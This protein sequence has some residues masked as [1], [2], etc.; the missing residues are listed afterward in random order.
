M[1]SKNKFEHSETMSNLV[2]DAFQKGIF[3]EASH[4]TKVMKS[5]AEAKPEVNL[6]PSDNVQENL[7]KLCAGLR[8]K[9]FAAYA[10]KVEDRIVQLKQAEVHLYNVHDETGEDLLEFAHPE[11]SPEVAESQGGHGVVEDLIA[12]HKKSVEVATKSAAIKNDVINQVKLALIGSGT[13]FLVSEAAPSAEAG[14]A[15][16][17]I[18]DS[19]KDR[20][21]Q[22]I[23]VFSKKGIAEEAGVQSLTRQITDT[24]MPS[25]DI[26]KRE[27]LQSKT[28]TIPKFLNALRKFQEYFK[29]SKQSGTFDSQVFKDDDTSLVAIGMLQ[30]IYKDL[31]SIS[32]SIEKG[33]NWIPP[34]DDKDK[35]SF[36]NPGKWQENQKIVDP[37][38]EEKP[39][40]GNT[41]LDGT[42]QEF[43]NVVA[44][45]MNKFKTLLD[46]EDKI[47][48][49]IPDND[50]AKINI[51]DMA[52]DRA[53]SAFKGFSE[54]Y[55][56]LESIKEVSISKDQLSE[57]C[58]N[59][60]I[61]RGKSSFNSTTELITYADAVYNSVL[62]ALGKSQ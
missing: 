3:K 17:S 16:A 51:F 12:E 27:A 10:E 55:K 1:T 41:V 59:L 62:K 49:P 38:K 13:S 31:E 18:I 39:V 28:E 29:T 56:S 35:V 34:V 61:F 20:F 6:E 25:L 32:W 60:N 54:L 48:E 42:V 9:G 37:K 45:S 52:F 21:S 22:L 4:I 24:F 14:T 30:G 2:K 58:K 47:Y 40:S 8:S 5:A 11:G 53:E 23:Q 33:Q 44:T 46:Q 57:K 50:T 36:K 19:I 7:F 43:K 26:I 15:Y